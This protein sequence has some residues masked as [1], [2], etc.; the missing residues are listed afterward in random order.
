MERP[1]ITHF[2]QYRRYLKAMFQYKKSLN[3]RYSF[4]VLAKRI[5]S[6]P[7]L[8][9]HVL[10]E[11][12]N[13]GINRVASVANAL[14]MNAFE[15]DYFTIQVLHD[16]TKN[17]V[18]RKYLNEVLG[19]LRFRKDSATTHYTE[20]RSQ[21]GEFL[22]GNWLAAVIH[23]MSK[24]TGF[25]DDP[26]WIRDRLLDREKIKLDEVSSIFN[27]LAELDLIETKGGT[28]TFKKEAHGTA[29]PFHSKSLEV[30]REFIGKTFEV[31]GNP[32]QYKT[33]QFFV[34]AFAVDHATEER[35][36][37]IFDSFRE[38][39]TKAAT[40]CKAPDRV[41]VVSNSLFNA[42]EKTN[43]IPPGPDG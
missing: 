41:L 27:R 24:M 16:I 38:Q 30:Y 6:S 23:Q 29:D 5:G 15:A 37:K 2:P 42:I 32:G 33:C 40:E 36:L 10:E 17:R 39:V 3:P 22:T 7:S 13:I 25:K 20:L 1:D 9:K 12:K 28:W 18:T 26:T 35:I 19:K 4:Q 31:L 43:P 21:A 34:S 14:E 8:M 11:R